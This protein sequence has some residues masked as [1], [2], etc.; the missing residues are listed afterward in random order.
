MLRQ[1]VGFLVRESCLQSCSPLLDLLTMRFVAVFVAVLLASLATIP[2]TVVPVSRA[3]LSDEEACC[4]TA[5]LKTRRCLYVCA[6][7]GVIDRRQNFTAAG[8]FAEPHR[9]IKAAYLS[10]SVGPSE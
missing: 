4:T 1:L 7:M 3:L 6:V 2:G 8:P 9:H 5:E 10:I